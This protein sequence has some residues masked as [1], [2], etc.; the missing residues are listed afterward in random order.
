MNALTSALVDYWTTLPSR[1]KANRL[2]AVAELRQP[3][4]SGD[5][6][7]AALLPYALGDG[8]EDVVFAATSAWVAV[9]PEPSASENAA[10]DAVEWVRRGLALNRGAVFAAL[11]SRGDESLNERLR[12]LRLCF[13]ER[14]VETVCRHV[15]RRRS[16]AAQAFL[17]DWHLLVQDD[18]EAGVRDCLARSLEECAQVA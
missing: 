5:L 6:S 11:L 9:R 4:E 14:E 12:G 2:R 17:R 15:A 10:A 13:A 7:P 18:G 16:A 3:I 1:P 8:D